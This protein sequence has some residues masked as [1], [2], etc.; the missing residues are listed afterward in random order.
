M[1]RRIDPLVCLKC[2]GEMRVIAFI[3]DHPVLDRVINYLKLTF[4]AAKP[5]PAQV[6]YQEILMTAEAATEYFS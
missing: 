6:A 3:T 4:V 2:Q 1:I 5:T